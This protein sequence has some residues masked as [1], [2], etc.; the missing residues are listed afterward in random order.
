MRR[1]ILV[2]VAAIAA[3]LL[4]LALRHSG[5]A[6]VVRGSSTQEFSTVR[7]PGSDMPA[8]LAAWPT[9]GYDL[10]RTHV[11]PVTFRLRPPYRKIWA[12]GLD[13]WAEFPPSV[14]YGN[15]YLAQLNGVV[16]AVS[17]RRGAPV[18]SQSFGPNCAPSAS[19][20]GGGARGRVRSSAGTLSLRQSC[21]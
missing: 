13:V 20:V 14:A 5:S 2:A 16:L 18:W 7:R 6:P 1:L 17:A 9:Y 10:A 4:G 8:A 3:V 21:E 12:R 11:A 19:D 15:V